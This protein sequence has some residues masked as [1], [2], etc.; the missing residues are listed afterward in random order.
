[1]MVDE[2]V[3]VQNEAMKWYPVLVG[4]LR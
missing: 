1:M 3:G 2:M 4:T